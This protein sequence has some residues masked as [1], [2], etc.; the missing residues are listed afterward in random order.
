MKRMLFS[1]FNLLILGLFPTG[2]SGKG[3]QTAASFDVR[4][5][6]L[7]SI[8]NV[9]GGGAMLYGNGPAGSFGKRIDNR[10][11][12]TVSLDIPNGTWNFTIIAWDGDHDANTST[13]PVPLTGL[14]RCGFSR[15]NALNGGDVTISLTLSNA[16]CGDS[17]FSPEVVVNAGLVNFPEF[18][19]KTCRVDLATVTDENATECTN[20]GEGFF[21]SIRIF[22]VP[23]R[24]MDGFAET[25]FANAIVGPC[26]SK[27]ATPGDPNFTVKEAPNAVAATYNIPGG[28]PAFVDSKFRTFVRGYFGET[29]NCDETDPRGVREL[30]ALSG[31]NEQAPGTRVIPYNAGV[32]E[33]AILMHTPDA[34]VCL[35]PRDSLVSDFSAGG[36]K[37]FYRGMCNGGQFDLFPL[38]WTTGATL[39]NKNIVLLR[40]IN[41]FEGLTLSP[42]M[43]PGIP[44]QAMIGTAFTGSEASEPQPY[45]GTFDGNNKRIVGMRIDK[46]NYMGVIRDLGFVRNLGTGGII[47]DLTF[48]LGEIWADS[49]EDHGNIGLVA[50][51][52]SGGAIQ[53]VSII[54]SDVEG[55]TSIGLVTGRMTA[56]S[57]DFVDSDD[58]NVE[59]FDNTGGLVGDMV[60]GTI[61]DSGFV[62]GVFEDGPNGFCSNPS[63]YD[64]NSCT[65]NSG[66]WTYRER[67]GGIVG[68]MSAGSINRSRSFGAVLGSANVGGLVGHV[69][70]SASI[71]DSYSASTVIAT[72][73]IGGNSHAGGVAGFDAIGVTMTRVFHSLGSI[74]GG[75]N[76]VGAV[77][78]A[79]ATTN[80]TNVYGTSPTKDGAGNATYAQIRDA[81]FLNGAGLNTADWLRS[82]DGFDFPRLAWEPIRD[83]SGKFS[84]TWAG[85]T[86]SAADPYLICSAAQLN[87]IG[88]QL[89]SGAFYKILRPLDLQ[90]LAQPDRA[91]IRNSD[92]TMG[93]SGTLSGEGMFINNVNFNNAGETLAQPTGLFPKINSDGV[94]REMVIVGL[95]NFTNATQTYPV[96]LVAGSNQGRI[97]MVRTFGGFTSSGADDQGIGGLVGVNEAVIIGS[98]SN[99]AIRGV[100]SVGGMVG[101]NNGGLIAYGSFGG[102]VSPINTTPSFRIGGI[103]GS[104]T[105]ATGGS[106]F[107]PVFNETISYNGLITDV[108]VRGDLSA[109]FG[110]NSADQTLMTES[111]LLVGY[112]NGIIYN[113]ESYG[114]VDLTLDN[115]GVMYPIYQGTFDASVVS[116]TTTSADGEIYLVGTASGGSRTIQGVTRDWLVGD[117]IWYHNGQTYVIPG[118]DIVPGYMAPSTHSAAPWVEFGLGI[119]VNDTSGDV[120][121][122]YYNQNSDYI[123]AQFFS[124][125]FGAFVGVNNGTVDDS[126]FE[127]SFNFPNSN[128]DHIGISTTNYM[129]N[130]MMSGTYVMV[131]AADTAQYSASTIFRDSAA[132]DF[133]TDVGVGDTVALGSYGMDI[134]G[135]T[136]ATTVTTTNE[137]G[138][139]PGGISFPL[140]VPLGEIST[141]FSGTFFE[142]NLPWAFGDY[143]TPGSEWKIRN[144][145]SEAGLIRSESYEELQQTQDYI[146]MIN[147][148]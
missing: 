39:N 31:L 24:E 63:Y 137:M 110:P 84:G 86:G 54:S 89:N 115:A 129:F 8:A 9:A 101:K 99:A 80:H 72:S 64:P 109:T 1:I 43:D 28:N 142:D 15:G 108:T 60:G 10:G 48:T 69:S 70:G 27:V 119:G 77:Y 146:D 32:D 21:N 42:G 38:E 87:N 14:V 98:H 78:G 135:I 111:G 148:L 22:F 113:I 127:G 71:S 112:N 83:C 29:A 68:Q 46:E 140:F 73:E 11:G 104:N 34:I 30:L 50:G 96:G 41:Y 105:P 18:K 74:I 47:K 107:N 121:N 12:E 3:G 97:D 93:F 2:C 116:T 141:D 36:N 76:S 37:F 4:L 91:I 17:V 16:D 65:S 55:Q 102:K 138:I 94:V 57:L 62:G 13:G 145:G 58:S 114:R 51:Q 90:G 25:D 134:N 56:G 120:S 66:T 85:G 136:D 103:A 133:T 82:D 61:N 139:T 124:P 100:S 122:V 26:L 23:Y 123:G 92:L 44:E 147:A 125:N 45:I 131:E 106:Y 35:P 95:G 19:P 81:T 132:I 5:G 144:S 118:L 6:G 79:G 49:Y 88:A 59:G 40:D 20:A 67:F 128:S 52:L 53:N 75:G 126:V 143:D 33:R 117:A 130:R 7:T